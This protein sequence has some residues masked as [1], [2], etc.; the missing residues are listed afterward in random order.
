[1]MNKP[2]T[3]IENDNVSSKRAQPDKTPKKGAKNKKA[4][5]FPGSPFCKR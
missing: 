2:P 5:V 3:T 4:L 1:M